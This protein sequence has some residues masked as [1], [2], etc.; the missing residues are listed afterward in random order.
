MAYASA[1]NFVSDNVVHEV[2]RAGAL[3]HS[4]RCPNGAEDDAG[5]DVQER[6]AMVG[7]DLAKHFRPTALVTHVQPVAI[8][9]EVVGFSDKVNSKRYAHH[10]HPSVHPR[11]PPTLV[12]GITLY[13]H[14]FQ[15]IMLL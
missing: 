15:V 7:R 2:Q 9:V 13:P 3:A 12:F 11:L 6:M 10:A 8:A 5:R 14:P 4:Y 1:L